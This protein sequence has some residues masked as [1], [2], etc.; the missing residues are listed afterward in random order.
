MRWLLLPLLLLAGA[1]QAA[2]TQWCENTQVYV[3]L[4]DICGSG[5]NEDCCTPDLSDANAGA[6][7]S[8]SAFDGDVTTDKANGTMYGC[9]RTSATAVRTPAEIIAGTGCTDTSSVT[10][11][12]AGLQDFSGANNFSGLA[13]ETE[14]QIDYHHQWDSDRQVTYEVETSPPVTT[15]AAVATACDYYVDPASGSDSNTGTAHDDAWQTLAKVNN[16]VTAVGSDVCLMSG[17]FTNETLDADWGGES[18][19]TAEI[20][21][22]YVNAGTAY[23]WDEGPDASNPANRVTIN[24]TNYTCQAPIVEI[25]GDYTNLSHID[26]TGS[27]HVCTNWF[28]AGYFIAIL[29]NGVNNVVFED[30]DIDVWDSQANARAAYKGERVSAYNIAKG[31]DVTI[32]DSVIRWAYN[33]ISVDWDASGIAILNNTISEHTH[34]CINLQSDGNAQRSVGLLIK[35]NDMSLCESLDSDG[36]QLNAAAGGVGGSMRNVAIIDNEIGGDLGENGIDLKGGGYVWVEGNIIHG[37]PGNN[38]GPCDA[39][40]QPSSIAC[41]FTGG[42]ND[43]RWGGAGGTMHGGGGAEVITDEILITGNV[44]YNGLGGVNTLSGTWFETHNTYIW[45]QKDYTGAGTTHDPSDEALYYGSGNTNGNCTDCGSLNNIYHLHKQEVSWKDG[46][47]VRLDGHVFAT[48]NSHD[49]RYAYGVDNFTEYTTLSGWIAALATSFVGDDGTHADACATCKEAAVTFVTGDT[50]PEGPYAG[51]GM[52]LNLQAGSGAENYA[53]PLTYTNGTGAASTS[54]T[55]D[56]ASYLRG[57]TTADTSKDW[58][59]PG[60]YIQIGGGPTVQIESISGEVLTITPADTW[61]DGEAIR[62]VTSGG[63]VYD[64]SGAC[65]INTRC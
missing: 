10:V 20:F 23:K 11:S 40:L 47:T 43:N 63:T 32:R 38:D 58:Y 31:T 53:I 1:A 34:H 45:N 59:H 28:D 62:R 30:V 49:P 18:G 65:Q 21:G 46:N 56:D 61:G 22:A 8:S 3:E 27:G 15:P 25:A 19:D 41:D 29:T 54:V 17:T 51:T 7:L 26:M 39:S 12:S 44:Y 16:S 60:M 2:E 4:T 52:D 37:F 5:D 6:N 55:V 57:H 50:S 35:G 33:G 9:A 13:A 48:D 64:D 14:Y 42:T 36:I 24:T